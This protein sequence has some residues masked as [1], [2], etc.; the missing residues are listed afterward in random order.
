MT[1]SYNWLNEYIKC[2]LTPEE[3]EVI[4]TDIGLEVDSLE[5]KEAVRG[6]LSGVVVGEVLTCEKHPDADKLKVTTVDVGAGEPLQ[7]VC[8]APNVAAGQKV[9]VATVNTTLYPTGEAE[10][11]KIKKSKIRGVE[12][13][14]MICAED[15]LGIGDSHEGIMVLDTAAPNGT[16]ASQVLELRDDYIIEI[17]LTPNR[18]DAASHYGVARDLAAYLRAHGRPCELSLPPVDGFA[19]G[20]RGREVTVE[21]SENEGAP[22]YTGVT[23]TD[24]KI[25]PSPEWLQ[26]HL[27]AIGLNPKNNVVDITNFVLHEVGQPL[28]A[29]DADKVK[30]DRIVVRTVPEGTK[31]TTLDEAERELSGEDLMICNAEEPMCIAGVFGGLESGVSDSTTAVFI[32]SAYFSP[33]WVRRTARR[34]G[35]STDSSFRFERGADPDMAIYAL[36][37]AA[38]LIKEYAGGNISSDITD[39]YPEPVQPFRF[40]LR[41]DYMARLIGKEIPLRTVKEILAALDVKIESEADGVLNVAVPPF[42]VDVQR[43]ADLVEDILRIYGYNNVDIPEHVNSTLSY[44]PTPNVDKLRNMVADMLSAQGFAET[45]S[46]SLTRS[47]YYADSASFPEAGCVRILNPLSADLNVMRQTLLFGMLEAVELNTN[48]RNP[49]LR[50]YEF[51]NCYK[52]LPEKRDDGG[53]APYR[54]TDT[55]AVAVCGLRHRPTWNEP[56]RRSDFFTLRAVA[57]QLLARFGLD[58]YKLEN[59]PSEDDRFSEAIEVMLNGKPLMQLGAVAAEYLRKFSLGQPVYFMEMDFGHLLKATRKHSI[60]VEELSKYPEVRRDLALLVDK[61]TTFARLRSAALQAE[62][63]LLTHVSLFDVYEGEKLPA[64]KK[65]YAL[66]FII[67]DKTRTLQDKDIDRI[68]NNIIARLEKECGAQVRS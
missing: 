52:Y 49:D 38:L 20:Q 13:L 36:K 48:R 7:I 59:R 65:S 44:P 32:E 66:S 1:I 50:L 25:A 11:F 21:V 46:N 51:G 9:L 62:R 68:M 5:K 58:I 67:E 6:G 41:T 63:K 24:I 34:H 19:V 23:I 3:M 18:S 16:P 14:G 53:L 39:I 57:E 40:A 29:F 10:G 35:L 60:K 37:R 43:P 4:L 54:E 55:L 8:G 26:N 27:R 2:G 31:F 12:S 33:K 47:S 64:G 17:G 56:E 22:R 15:E 28:H 42:R 45:M 61:E 30:G